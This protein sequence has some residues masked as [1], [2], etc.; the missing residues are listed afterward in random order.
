MKKIVF[1]IML[2]LSMQVYAKAP[3]VK[4]TKKE[5]KLSKKFLKLE[6][7]QQKNLYDYVR[8][9]KSRY[10]LTREMVW[11]STKIVEAM[12]VQSSMILIKEK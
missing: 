9:L 12:S 4:V 7:H 11:T 6:R 1:F 2:S 8:L 3:L 10:I 5:L